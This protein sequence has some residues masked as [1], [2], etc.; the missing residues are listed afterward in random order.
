M[1]I[2]RPQARNAIDPETHEAL[3]ATWADFRDDDAVDV[4]I[5]T[6]AGDEA[7]CAGADLKTYIPP[8]IRGERAHPRDRRPRARRPHARAAPHPQAG[9][10]GGQRL[11]AGGRA[12]DWRWP[13]TSASPPSARVRLLRGAPRL[14]PRRRRHRAAGQRLRRRG[15]ARTCCSP[16]SRS[17]PARRCS[18]TS[19]R[20]SSPHDAL[21]DEAELVGAPDPAQLPARGALGQGDD[22]RRDRQGP[23]RP[24]AHRGVE[25]ATPCADPDETLGL[26]QRFYDRTRRGPRMS[27]VLELFPPGAAVDAGGELVVG[28][29]R[30]A[31]TS[32]PSSAR[33]PTWS[34]RAR[35]ATRAREYRDE[36]AA[37]WPDA[38]V[39]LR[40]QGL[41]LHGG[42][43]RH[44]RGGPR[45]ATSPA[46]ASWCMALAAGVDP[47]A[48]R[49]ARQR[50][51]R[52]RHRA[53]DRRTASGSVVIDNFD[54]IDRLERRST[55]EQGVL[56]RVIPGVA[57]RHPRRDRR[58]ART[59]RSSASRRPTRAG[60][61]SGC[62]ARTALRLDGLHVHVGSQILDA[63]P[64]RPGGRRRSPR[65]A[66]SRSTTSA[67]GS[68][69]ATPTPTARR[70]SPSTSTRWCGAAREH[71]PGGARS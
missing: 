56:V 48:H 45:A 63:A 49:P 35:C 36:L 21:M 64:L 43:A 55:G 37:R 26:L 29:C 42:P 46:P 31:T 57:G 19:S 6:G 4:A 17:T 40:L 30:A 67:A 28:G 32:P 69:P 23:R 2:N 34:T 65:S 59:A 14:P 62:A 33:R 16:P 52:R 54:D 71:L 41:P 61:S 70:A 12:G 9:D 11:G 20:R 13:A 58:P 27:D 3:C 8:I 25:R 68:A 18:G 66:S 60:R 7:F 15:G 38:L 1:T 53:R 47:G 51:D 50:E 22:P 39:G 24:A 10:R 44:G 5:L